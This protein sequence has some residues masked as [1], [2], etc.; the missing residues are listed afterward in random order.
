MWRT[1]GKLL[2]ML[3]NVLVLAKVFSVTAFFQQTRNQVDFDKSYYPSVQYIRE[4]LNPYTGSYMQTLGPPLVF[5]YFLP[6]SLMDLH[7][8]QT[9][10][11]VINL[12]AGYLT[13][14]VLAVRFFPKV[15]AIAFGGL[16]LL[17]Y[18]SFLSR[19]SLQMGQ[20]NLVI[21]LLVALVI[22]TVKFR[23]FLLCTLVVMKTFFVLP[24]L[25]TTS[26]NSKAGRREVI[27]NAMSL[28]LVLVISLLFI[29]PAWYKDY[30]FR[31]FTTLQFFQTPPASNSLQYEN[32]TFKTTLF[33]LG[34]GNIYIYLYV[35]LIVFCLVW[36]LV[37]PN[38]EVSLLFSF[39]ISPVLWQHYFIAL[40]PMFVKTFVEVRT[41]SYT[42]M[43]MVVAAFVL[44]WPDLRLW[45]W[46][47]NWGTGILASHFFIALAILTGV[48]MVYCLKIFP[49]KNII[50]RYEDATRI[51]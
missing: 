22:S 51:C 39:I 26:I 18:G 44:W 23:Q 29:K 4:G 13:C 7:T 1:I 27:K 42:M 33:R 45:D 3:V 10:N 47:V 36:L 24:F 37:H 9:V 40:F 17:F 49:G 25:P 34:L 48:R 46:P 12:A 8:A 16:S 31:R 38:L 32:Q 43:W 14:L 6:F 20:P 19:Y 11:L 28:I 5:L 15:K 41:R 35:G 2:L 30:S 21:A 50:G